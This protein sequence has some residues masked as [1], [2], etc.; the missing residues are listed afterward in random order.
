M[1]ELGSTAEEINVTAG[2]EDAVTAAV[3]EKYETEVLE[4]SV[5]CDDSVAS[6][7]SEFSVPSPK[8]DG[9]I[10]SDRLANVLHLTVQKGK[11]GHNGLCKHPVLLI[12]ANFL[13]DKFQT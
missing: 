13:F 7:Q 10:S 2:N 1:D 12:T 5:S 4:K 6:L 8:E 3:T 11:E 9:E